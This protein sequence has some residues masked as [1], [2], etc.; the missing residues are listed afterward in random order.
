MRSDNVK[1]ECHGIRCSEDDLNQ[2]KN[3]LRDHYRIQDE[4]AF[5]DIKISKELDEFKGVLT[6]RNAKR[7]AIVIKKSKKLE[8]LVQKLLKISRQKLEKFN[9]PRIHRP[10]LGHIIN[11]WGLT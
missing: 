10:S 6:I 8:G 4:H 2:L 1:I 5:Y 7:K 9:S 3:S 11:H